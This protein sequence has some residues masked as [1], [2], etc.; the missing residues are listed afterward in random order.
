VK[1]NAISIIKNEGLIMRK[2]SL[3]ILCPQC[4]GGDS[5][6]FYEHKA[7]T[8]SYCGGVKKVDI[9]DHHKALNITDVRHENV[10]AFVTDSRFIEYLEAKNKR[11]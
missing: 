6:Y 10:I 9:L 11:R 2:R 4:E 7:A 3:Q 8:C 1:P 5:R